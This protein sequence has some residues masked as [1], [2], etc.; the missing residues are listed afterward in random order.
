MLLD[1][2]YNPDVLTCLANLSSDEVFTPPSLANEML[3]LLPKKLWSDKNA[4]FLDPACKSGV[5]LRE[6]AK[7][8]NE[9]LQAQIPN[10]QQRLNH[11]YTKQLFAISIT[12]LTALLSRRSVYCSKLANGKY[13]VCDEF[14][15]AHGNILYERTEHSWSR[16]RCVHCGASEA[17]FEEE[18]RSALESHAYQFIHT[19][20]AKGI[21]DM[22]FDVIIGNPPYQL[23]TAGAQAQATPIYDK[24]VSQAIKLKPR[25][26]SMIIP[27]KWFAG[28]MGL[29]DFRNQ[30]LNDRRLRKIVDFPDST[31]CFPN[32]DISGGVCY[33]LWERDWDGDCEV[34]TQ[35]DGQR[36]V[37]S[38]PL[39]E[40]GAD[41]F[42]R[43]NQ[44]IS[45]L[46]KVKRLNEPSFTNLVSSQK[47][48]GFAT[49]FADFSPKH[50]KGAIKYYGYNKTGYV[51]ESQILQNQDWVGQYK[52]YISQAYGERIASSYWVLGK[53]FLGEPL[54]CCS[55]TYLVIGP[56]KSE[57]IALNVM[58]YMR[59]RFFRFL[60]L[61]LKNT[62]HA[63][64]KVYKLAPQQDFTQMWDDTK[65]YS[66]YN[67]TA[68]EISFIESM[69]RSMEPT[70]E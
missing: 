54:S 16:G 61:L 46:H 15:D 23:K 37:M 35:F 36:S 45:I 5:F 34:T 8:L 52:V 3:D 10:L 30:M 63:P 43:Y 20:D 4:T 9:G 57:A 69:V 40:Q 67:L 68:A 38:R 28:G 32:V 17:I 62:Q 55:E 6:I 65:L 56:V 70:D 49:N 7:R 14:E 27:S 59:T 33:F 50:F 21:F 53:P 66:K 2:N 22:K 58:S 26:L 48:F 25:Y 13:S 18:K 41:S 39:L 11:I 12:E 19:N 60:V 51:K 24:F 42:I 44:S 64:K 47:P 29:N 1:A 31:D